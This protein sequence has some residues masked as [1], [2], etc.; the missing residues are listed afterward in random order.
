[1]LDDIHKLLN[2]YE[3]LIDAGAQELTRVE[4]TDAFF[5]VMRALED[6]VTQNILQNVLELDHD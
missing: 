3:R 5:P 4:F 1:M 2:A 6:R